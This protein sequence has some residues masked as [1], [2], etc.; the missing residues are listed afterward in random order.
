MLISPRLRRLAAALAAAGSLAAV[1]AAPASANH[2]VLP[3][4]DMIAEPV[5]PE[6]VRSPSVPAC[7]NLLFDVAEN[8]IDSAERTYDAHVRP[9]TCDVHWILEGEECA[10]P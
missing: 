3:T 9:W 7:V 6:C 10:S 5:W 4:E 8:G 2:M 1:G